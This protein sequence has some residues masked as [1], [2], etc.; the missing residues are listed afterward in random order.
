MTSIERRCGTA[1][2][3][4]TAFVVSQML[5]ARLARLARKLLGIDGNQGGTQLRIEPIKKSLF[6]AEWRLLGPPQRAFPQAVE[7]AQRLRVSGEAPEPTL[8]EH[9]RQVRRRHAPDPVH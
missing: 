6:H 5:L 1:R 2:E 7:R 3:G 8:C 9:G 4:F